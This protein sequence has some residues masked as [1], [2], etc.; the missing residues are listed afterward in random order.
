MNFPLISIATLFCSLWLLADMFAPAL[1]EDAYCQFLDTIAQRTLR[2]DQDAAAGRRLVA[3]DD[4]MVIP[5][6]VYELVASEFPK[7]RAFPVPR[8]PRESRKMYG[9]TDA[10]V[11]DEEERRDECAEAKDEPAEGKRA[12]DGLL[13]LVRPDE[14]DALRRDSL[15]RS[16]TRGINTGMISRLAARK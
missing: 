11:E 3:R 6:K 2:Q 4:E 1:T 12:E 7:W 16:I 9:R 15:A 14:Q 10:Q 13:P 5:R 8:S